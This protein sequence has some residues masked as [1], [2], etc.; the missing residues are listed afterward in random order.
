MSLK[1][2]LC[3]IPIVK[4]GK[5]IGEKLFYGI[6]FSKLFL[7]VLLKI[8]LICM[9]IWFFRV[10]VTSCYFYPHFPMHI[11]F[12][13]FDILPSDFSKISQN[14]GKIWEK[15]VYLLHQKNYLNSNWQPLFHIINPW[16]MCSKFCIT[17]IP[18]QILPVISHIHKIIT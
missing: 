12:F 10:F 9:K 16:A 2:S 7:L 3:I 18:V 17:R 14:A 5:R 1:G 4:G 8:W 15:S 13:C 6:F 11:F